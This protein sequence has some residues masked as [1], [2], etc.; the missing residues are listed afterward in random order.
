MTL[1][2]VW[3]ETNLRRCI[4]KFHRFVCDCCDKAFPLRSALELHK[5]TSHPDKPPAADSEEAEEEAEEEP[6]EDGESENGEEERQDAETDVVS[7]EQAGFLEAFG[8]QHTSK[9][10]KLSVC[11][12]F[13]V[14]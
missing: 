12:S 14:K 3:C 11:S 10:S 7:S 4:S 5:T 1:A 2:Q 8:L 6:E 9:V 13:V